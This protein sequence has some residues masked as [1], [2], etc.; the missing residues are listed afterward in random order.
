MH[1]L[2]VVLN[3]E[4]LWRVGVENAIMLTPSLGVHACTEFPAIFDVAGMCVLPDGRDAHVY[5]GD[6]YPVKI[7]DI[8]T[9]TFVKSDWPTP[10]TKT[11]AVD[12]PTY[13]EE[14]RWFDEFSETY[15]GPEAPVAALWKNVQVRCIVNGQHQA[16]AAMS[17]SEAH[18]LGSLLWNQWHPDRCRV[19]VRSFGDLSIP[20]TQW[21]NTDLALNDCIEFLIQST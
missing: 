13:V 4:L 17:L 20:E 9:I 18:I 11:M 19:S 5:W 3:G 10:P 12:D 14:Q 6:S 15:M 2:E 8:L 21:L 16:I 1:C 7:G